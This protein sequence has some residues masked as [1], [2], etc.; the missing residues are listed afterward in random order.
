MLQRLWKPWFIWRPG[1]I[2]RRLRSAITPAPD[3]ALPLPTS[4]GFPLRVNARKSIG[5]AI[6]NTGLY[7]PVLSEILLRLIPVGGT[8]VD[9]GA[10]VGHMTLIM[11]W[12][13]GPEG[14]VTAF[15]P[16]PELRRLLADNVERATAD[17]RVAPIQIEAQAVGDRAGTARLLVPAGFSD[18]DGISRIETAG[19]TA[20]GARLDVPMTT[21]DTVLQERSLD[22][23]KLD[24][25]GHEAAVLEGARAALDAG[26]I[27]HILFEEHDLAGSTVVPSL[28][29][30]GYTLY[31]LAWRVDRPQVIP[32][33]EEA[34][35]RDGV[36]PNYLATLD[37]VAVE[38]G[39]RPAGWRVLRNRIPLR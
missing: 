31:S 24:V 33:A 10:N 18:N 25:E 32:L 16:H 6:R 12:A 29:R 3:A 15:E 1:Q 7:D 8:A 19:E 11:A 34:V 35:A 14:Q 17:F 36:M 20:E 21:L 30:A 28:R 27:R 26:W 2:V 38:A 9:V 4:W 37:P 5:R 22:V 23:L 39:M 13:A